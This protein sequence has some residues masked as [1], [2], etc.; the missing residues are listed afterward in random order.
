M[1]QISFIIFLISFCIFAAIMAWEPR[2]LWSGFSFFQMML[3]LM[4]FLFFL[5]SQYYEWLAAH[6]LFIGFLAVLVILAICVMIAFPGLLILLFLIE[7][8]KIIRHEGL[9]LSNLLS[10]LFSLSLFG[11]LIVLPMIGALGKNTFS[12]KL[13]TIIS[14]CVIYIL[15]LM[16]IYSFS[17]ILNLIHLRKKRKADYIVVLGAGLIGD[18]VTPLLASRIEKGMKLLDYNPDAKIIMSGGQGQGEDIA[19]GAAM[20]RYAIE[21]GVDKSRVIVEEK[22]VS[23]Q[24]NLVFSKEL[25]TGEQPKIIVVTTAYH[26]FRALLLAKK[27]GIKCVGFGSK[28]K[29][30]FTLNAIIREFA[31]YLC[32]TWKRH[33]LVIGIMAL[34][35]IV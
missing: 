4:A 26:V 24:E 15:S 14:F 12:T 35:L 29:W 33:A 11:Y 34:A 10:I 25:M 2:T 32:L 7:G 30:Y 1:S 5:V 8:I 13:Y 9:K 19:E 6:E 31:G 23:T 16:A 21:K 27:L 18:R 17:A 3:C 20:A 22:S 28:T